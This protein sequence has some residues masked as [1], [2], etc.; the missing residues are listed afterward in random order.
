[1]GG[2]AEGVIAKSPLLQKTERH[3]TINENLLRLVALSP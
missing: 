3:R 1:M 2:V